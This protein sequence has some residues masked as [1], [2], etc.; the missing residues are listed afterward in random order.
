[1]KP[2][3]PPLRALATLLA[4]NEAGNGEGGMPA[5][6]VVSA[7]VGVLL[8]RLAGQAG[9]RSLVM[10]ALAIAGNEA[11]WLNTLNVLPDGS[12]EGLEEARSNTD[13]E[14]IENGGAIFVAHL[15]HLLYTFIGE[16]LT[17]QLIKE[18]WPGVT[19]ENESPS[20]A[21]EQ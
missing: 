14:E 18:A 10:R 11:P 21:P 4:A 1:M 13:K 17:M 16:A 20:K 7:K 3:P 15:L 9:F 2:A 19:A 8:T 6:M 12:F 5:A